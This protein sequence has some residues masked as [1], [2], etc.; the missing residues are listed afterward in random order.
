MLIQS[1]ST[2]EKCISKK[3]TPVILLL[4]LR[5]PKPWSFSFWRAWILVVKTCSRLWDTFSK[6][7]TSSAL[8]LP[9]IE[10]MGLPQAL[11]S[12]SPETFST[13]RG[14][15]VSPLG[16]HSAF[17]NSQGSSKELLGFWRMSDLECFT[18]W[19]SLPKEMIQMASVVERE[20]EMVVY[21]IFKTMR[22]SSCWSLWP[23]AWNLYGNPWSFSSFAAFWHEGWFSDVILVVWLLSQDSSCLRGTGLLLQV[24]FIRRKY[25]CLAFLLPCCGMGNLQCPWTC[26]QI[27]TFLFVCK[28]Y[29]KQW[30]HFSFVNDW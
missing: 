8:V 16:Q 17:L 1:F 27:S 2:G 6:L 23:S 24:P 14:I 4:H 20:L 5:N 30:L 11:R 13:R 22:V 18:L 21:P 28:L 9:F 15:I 3:W 26:F 29:L 10:Q 7:R 25:L 12:R 19:F